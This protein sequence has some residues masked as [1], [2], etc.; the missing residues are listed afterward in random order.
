MRRPDTNVELP[1]GRRHTFAQ[2]GA[3]TLA[4]A[5]TYLGPRVII[6]PTAMVPEAEHLRDLGVPDP[7]SMLSAH[8]DCLVATHYPPA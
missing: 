1:D 5:K 7:F 4:G 8:P 3:G 6:S 2:L